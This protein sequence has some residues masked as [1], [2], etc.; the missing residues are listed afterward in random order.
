V[1]GWL[2][3]VPVALSL[4]YGPYTATQY[5][6]GVYENETYGLLFRVLWAFALS[7]LIFSCH[8]GNGGK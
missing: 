4:V 1:I 2:I 3:S 6:W 5:E 7:W 8:N